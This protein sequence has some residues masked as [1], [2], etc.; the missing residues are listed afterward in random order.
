MKK[1]YGKPLVSVEVMSLDQPVALNCV[2]DKDD[3]KSLMEFGYFMDGKNCTTNL[4]P[5]GGFDLNGDGAADSH[6]TLCYHS[7]VQTAFL[8]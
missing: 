1:A 3:I 4:L 8:S 5:S 6:D 7:N 2:A